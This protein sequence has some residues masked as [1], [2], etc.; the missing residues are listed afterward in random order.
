MY[1]QCKNER[2][3][4]RQRRIEQ[5]FLNLLAQ[6]DYTEISVTE[7]CQVI[8]IPRK[9]FY[10]YFGNKKGALRSLIEHTLTDYQK[11][12]PIAF[13]RSLSGEL[14]WFFE[15]WQQHKQFLDV[16]CSNGLLNTFLQI[17]TEFSLKDASLYNKFFQDE[18]EWARPLLFKFAVR[19][20]VTTMLDWHA[21]GFKEDC[22]TM[23][24]MA[25]RML[26]KPLFADLDAR[27]FA[28]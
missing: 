20:L 8:E 18:P 14:T 2:S 3:A 10:R 1:K 7:I 24:A 27:G 12:A 25:A 16:L 6:R 11:D 26:T 4:K 15:F 21:N 13:P 23:A 22:P 19:G 5:S 28:E 17:C 9:A